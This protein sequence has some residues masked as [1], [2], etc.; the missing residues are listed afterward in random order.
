MSLF[1]AECFSFLRSA[2]VRTP[3]PLQPVQYQ[4]LKWVDA[5]R[6]NGHLFADINPL[7]S[8]KKEQLSVEQ[9]DTENGKSNSG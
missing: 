7:K 6:W 1:C 2:A 8:M 3:V 4:L 9:R 5:Y